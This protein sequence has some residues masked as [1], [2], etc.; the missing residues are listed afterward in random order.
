MHPA[1]RVISFEHRSISSV[2]SGLSHFAERGVE[3]KKLPHAAVFRAMLHYLDLFAERMHHPK[4][5][6]HLFARLRE[7]TRA[8]DDM[9]DRLQEDHAWDIGA[10]RALEQAFLRY[11]EGGES[12]FDAFARQVQDYAMFHRDHMRNEETV[13]FPLAEEAL[14]EDDWRHIDAAFEAHQD[15]LA[16]PQEERDLKTLFTRIVT[17]TPSPIGVGDELA[18]RGHAQREQELLHSR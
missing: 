7:R 15:P 10:V 2:L 17:I 4:E 1:L 18:Q 13:I 9:L 5:D 16:S 6:L 11:E 12:F 8:A 14:T 3:G